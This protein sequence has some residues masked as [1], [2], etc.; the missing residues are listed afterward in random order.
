MMI[1]AP[2]VGNSALAAIYVTNALIKDER[3]AGGQERSFWIK[4]LG[5]EDLM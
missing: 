4:K 2:V 3:G 1:R 5:V